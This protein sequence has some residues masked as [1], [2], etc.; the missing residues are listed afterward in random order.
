LSICAE[1]SSACLA[2]SF[3]SSVVGSSGRTARTSWAGDVPS[4]AASEIVS[5]WASRSSTWWAVSRS[6]AAMLPKPS[7]STSP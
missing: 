5:N 7:E 1:A 3:T 4:L 6:N 2:L